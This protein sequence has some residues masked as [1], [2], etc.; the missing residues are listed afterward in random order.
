MNQM[1][2]KY[3]INITKFLFLKSYNFEKKEYDIPLFY[4][5]EFIL[6]NQ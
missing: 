5:C 4:Q 6:I 1:T 3:I 2:F